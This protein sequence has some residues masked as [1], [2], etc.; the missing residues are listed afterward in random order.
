MDPFGQ[1][2]KP[3]PPLALRHYAWLGLDSYFGG[4]AGGLRAR[5]SHEALIRAL[6]NTCAEYE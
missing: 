1:G 4:R 5:S 2:N 6:L 3:A